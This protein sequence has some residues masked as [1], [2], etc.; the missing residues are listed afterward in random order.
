MPGRSANL[1]R[2]VLHAPQPLVCS[3]SHILRR[4][5][6]RRR[7]APSRK[8]S[9]RSVNHDHPEV[10][11]L[12]QEHAETILDLA[13]AIRNSWVLG[14][15]RHAPRC[16]A[17][18]TT[19]EDRNITTRSSHLASQRSTVGLDTSSVSVGTCGDAVS[20]L[21]GHRPLRG[22]IHGIQVYFPMCFM[23]SRVLQT[24][25]QVIGLILRR[26]GTQTH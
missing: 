2:R 21:R 1:R 24:T 8:A 18:H 26:T 23:S 20:P 17:A 14:L 13:R 4:P 10:R 22:S 25:P 9:V 16:Q 7:D 11:F 6:S 5:S 19:H 12:V 3:S 15:G